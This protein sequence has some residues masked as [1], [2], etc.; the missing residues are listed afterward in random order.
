MYR[1]PYK[2]IFL[3]NILS[4]SSLL[5]YSRLSWSN[6]KKKEILKPITIHNH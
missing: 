6:N 1:N 4:L 2:D 5:M 3:K